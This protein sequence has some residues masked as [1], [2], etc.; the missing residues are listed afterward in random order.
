MPPS[1]ARMCIFF[2]ED[3]AKN[4]SVLSSDLRL[5]FGGSLLEATTTFISLLNNIS[6]SGV[7]APHGL[8]PKEFS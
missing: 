5:E 7:A 8:K 4:Y 1:L 6:E 3:V 2:I